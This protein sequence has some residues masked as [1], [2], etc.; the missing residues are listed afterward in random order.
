[1]IRSRLD[2]IRARLLAAAAL[3]PEAVGYWFAGHVSAE[4]ASRLA[5]AALGLVAGLW[6]G[7][8]PLQGSEAGQRALQAAANASATPHQRRRVRSRPTLP[9]SWNAS[10]GCP[11]LPSPMWP[12]AT[13]TTRP[14]SS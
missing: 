12:V 14:C 9:L 10:V 5:A 6:H 1:M 7:R 2:S 3:A 11:S 4:P 13:P 8:S